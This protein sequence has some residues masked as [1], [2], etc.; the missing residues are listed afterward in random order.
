MFLDIL[1]F[2]HLE[3]VLWFKG[4][5]VEEAYN[6]SKIDELKNVLAYYE[7]VREIEEI[8]SVLCVPKAHQLLLKKFKEEGKAKLVLP[9]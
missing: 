6:D 7:R 4:S 5:L 9:V 3:R 1:V 2:P 8:K